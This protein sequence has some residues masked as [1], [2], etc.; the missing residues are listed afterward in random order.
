MEPKIEFVDTLRVKK[1]FPAEAEYWRAAYDQQVLVMMDV[2][3]GD[4]MLVH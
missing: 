4:I 1:E 3:T 2:D